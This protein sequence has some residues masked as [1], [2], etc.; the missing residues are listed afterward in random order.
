M[1][2]IVSMSSKNEYGKQ[3]YPN[4]QDLEVN[5][6]SY[7]DYCNLRAGKNC[8]ELNILERLANYNSL[9][10]EP[11]EYGRITNTLKKNASSYPELV[12]FSKESPIKQQFSIDSLLVIDSQG[13]QIKPNFVKKIEKI[14]YNKENYSLVIVIDEKFQSVKEKRQIKLIK[15]ERKKKAKKEEIKHKQYKDISARISK[16]LD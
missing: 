13:F 9:F 7:Y 11:D 12:L 6:W 2:E 10:I 5:I 15:E 3:L 16:L 8:S 4:N 1:N 14:Y